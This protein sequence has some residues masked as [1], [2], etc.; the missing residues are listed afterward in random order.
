MLAGIPGQGGA[1]WAVLQYLLGLRKLGHEVVFV[2]PVAGGRSNTRSVEYFEAVVERFG[3]AGSAALL[4]PA[5]GETI[6]VGR[7]ALARFA[8]R[9][10]LL[11]N[12]SGTL[13]ED[14]LTEAVPVRAFVDLDPA[15]TQ[16]WSETGI[17]MGF[18]RHNRFV[19]IGGRIG[20][21]G[22]DVPTCGRDWVT[23]LQPVLLESWPYAESVEHDALTTVGHW[24]AYGSIEH[25]G[26]H[27]GQKAHSLRPLLALPGRSR[28]RF[29]LA[30]GIHPDEQ[31]DLVAMREHGWVLVDPKI[32]AA[33]PDTYADFVRGS[34]AEFA[35]AKSGYATSACG[36]FS[37]RSICYL[38][39]G[40]PVLAL[41]T[42]F[43]PD[44]PSGEGLLAFS[45]LDE[46]AGG[47]EELRTH[48]G[49]HRRAAREL[50]EDLFESDL[51]LTRL[52]SCL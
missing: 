43:S 23:T 17:D 12:I 7:D 10:D 28:A 27:Y 47:V 21:D 52:L 48:Y 32:A 39:S 1:S 36:W 24:R 22:C 46:A 35:L 40:R 6:G 44:V 19:T 20:S 29:E 45:S 31:P 4:D 30:L 13:A 11:L 49:R 50:A 5:T 9:A 33:S 51:V 34:W 3:L 2:E 42:G 14:H 41:D 38:A 37:D 8:T 16:L 15:F 18:D 26:V 25:E